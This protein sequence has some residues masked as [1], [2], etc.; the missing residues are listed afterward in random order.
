MSVH[1]TPGE[2]QEL[3]STR[4]AAWLLRPRPKTEEPNYEVINDMFDDNAQTL[5][6]NIQSNPTY[7]AIIGK[8]L[9]LLIVLICT[10]LLLLI[11]VTITLVL[12][13]LKRTSSSPSE[14]PSN[15]PSENPSNSPSENPSNSPS[16]F[17]EGFTTKADLQA[18]VAVYCNDSVNYQ[19]SKYG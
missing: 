9:R 18:E 5:S 14:N 16:I 12:V 10:A 15:S 11:A 2:G 7:Q 19:S 13:V 1:T 17:Y 8:R 3:R 6:P 4:T